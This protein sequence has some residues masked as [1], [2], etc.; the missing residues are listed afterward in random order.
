MAALVHQSE[1]KT[2][3]VG[4]IQQSLLHSESPGVAWRI[5]ETFSERMLPYEL[6]VQWSSGTAV[7]PVSS[8]TV[9]GSA[10]LCVLARTIT[11]T[12]RNL[13]NEPNKIQASVENGC[14]GTS[15]VWVFL[16]DCTGGTPLRLPIPAFAQSVRVEL[17][18]PDDRAGALLSLYYGDSVCS[19]CS[20]LEQPSAGL[21]LGG[22]QRIELTAPSVTRFRA[23]YML[24]F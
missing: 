6:G 13:A 21:L 5:V 20:V 18:N 2:L 16:S 8:V 9:S 12:A 24:S 11:L 4:A 22:C 15:N 1:G 14:I 17:P 3:P 10:R 7:G 23:L 19:C